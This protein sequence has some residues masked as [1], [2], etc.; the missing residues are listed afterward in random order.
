MIDKL[1]KKSLLSPIVVFVFLIGLTISISL[2]VQI[3][4]NI[5][6]N[7]HHEIEYLLKQEAY[8]IQKEIDQN[9]Q[10]LESVKS[11]Y[12][13]SKHVDRDEFKEFLKTPLEKYKSIQAITWI[14]YVQKEQRVLFE[15]Q[16]SKELD[17][18]FHIRS[19]YHDRMIISHTKDVYFPIYYIESL[20]DYDN[21][22]GFDLASNNKSLK[23]LEEAVRQR[24]SLSVTNIELLQKHA[25][26]TGFFV[27]VPLPIE[28]FFLGLDVPERLVIILA[29]K[30][31]LVYGSIKHC[32][33]V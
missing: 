31:L 4:L 28:V 11:F 6:E 26:K 22:Y 30:Y 1:N 23:T 27:Y 20:K 2:Y 24:T 21:V 18:Q 17:K 9:L 3:S 33:P 8:N 25:N 15:K 29:I 32:N 5:K 13:S 10:V 19:Q 16:A 12:N 7:T 14:P